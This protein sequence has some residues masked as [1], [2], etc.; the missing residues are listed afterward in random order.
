MYIQKGMFKLFTNRAHEVLGQCRTIKLAQT[1]L[2]DDWLLHVQHIRRT[3][4]V[5]KNHDHGV[6]WL[7]NY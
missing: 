2:P 4:I 1:M 5:R 3:G 7:V 6:L